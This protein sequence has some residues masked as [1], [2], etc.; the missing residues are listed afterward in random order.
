MSSGQLP[1]IPEPR[2]SDPDWF[3][4]MKVWCGDIVRAIARSRLV[5]DNATLREQNGIL[6]AI[7]DFPPQ[8]KVEQIDDTSVFVRGGIAGRWDGASSATVSLT[9][10]GAG[11]NG[12]GL[13]ALTISSITASQWIQIAVDDAYTPTTLTASATGGTAIPASNDGTVI[14]VAYIYCEDS[15]IVRIFQ[16]HT[17]PWYLPAPVDPDAKSLDRNTDSQAEIKGW[18]APPAGGAVAATDRLIIRV[19]DVGGVAPEATFKTAEAFAAYVAAYVADNCS[20]SHWTDCDHTHDHDL[21]YQ[22]IDVLVPHTHGEHT[23]YNTD[24]HDMDSGV[25]LL[26]LDGGADRNKMSGVIGDAAGKDSI[27]PNGRACIDS[28]GVLTRIYWEEAY[29]SIAGRL[30]GGRNSVVTVATDNGSLGWHGAVAPDG[31]SFEVSADGPRIECDETIRLNA[32]LR[33]IYDSWTIKNA[34]GGAEWRDLELRKLVSKVAGNDAITLEDNSGITIGSDAFVRT[35]FKAVDPA[36][37][38]TYRYEALA[39]KVEPT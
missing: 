14:P 4:Q 3:R 30:T 25:P 8:F 34:E 37:G 38:E 27:Q 23:A 36:D 7:P 20:L 16:A 35:Q 11:T 17:G 13:E 10:D 19:T 2:G 29:T 39:R 22:K 18:A 24:D 15:V 33:E 1:R 26:R 21:Q 6:S 9:V 12:T 28:G 31:S 32:K 5:A